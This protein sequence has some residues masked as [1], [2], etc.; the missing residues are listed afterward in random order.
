MNFT[1]LGAERT[2][3]FTV[4]LVGSRSRCCSIVQLFLVPC[5]SRM[6]GPGLEVPSAILM[7]ICGP[8]DLRIRGPVDKYGDPDCKPNVEAH[9]HIDVM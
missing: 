5:R 6:P 8:V 7:N 4:G 1:G 2:S 9:I 3:S